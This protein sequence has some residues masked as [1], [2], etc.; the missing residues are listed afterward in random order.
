[1]SNSVTA[2]WDGLSQIPQILSEV[3]TSVEALKT[4]SST[5]AAAAATGSPIA[6]AAIVALGAELA[7][8]LVDTVKALDDDIDGMV[9]SVRAYQNNEEAV[10]GL[11]MAGINAV[12]ATS[13]ADRPALNRAS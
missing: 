2:V 9:N 13:Q 10:V 7:Y 8:F 5:P 4:L 12:L 6:S 11:A 3:R 1:M